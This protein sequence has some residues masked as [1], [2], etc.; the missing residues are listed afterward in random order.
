MT[1]MFLTPV[2]HHIDLR[3]QGCRAILSLSSFKVKAVVWSRDVGPPRSSGSS[4]G[5]LD[6]MRCLRGV[7]DSFRGGVSVLLETVKET[8]EPPAR[9][10]RSRI[11]GR[12]L[13][14]SICFPGCG[15]ASVSD[16]TLSS[17]ACLLCWPPPSAH[18]SDSIGALCWLLIDSIILGM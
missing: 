7:G 4:D 11:G 2:H 18:V 6:R 17:L 16:A 3:P 1:K 15:D 12:G 13:C 10:S 9:S 5:S 8:A 14:R